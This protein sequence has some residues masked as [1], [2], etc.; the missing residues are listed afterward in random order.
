[1]WRAALADCLARQEAKK[2]EEKQ[3]FFFP[4]FFALHL[5][6][7]F[8]YSLVNADC[9]HAHTDTLHTLIFFLCPSKLTY[10]SFSLSNNYMWIRGKPQRFTCNISR[11]IR[12]LL[13][14]FSLPQKQVKYVPNAHKK[15]QQHLYSVITIFTIYLAHSFPQLLFFLSWIMD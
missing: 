4:S 13:H 6:L 1:M 7:V 2:A 5:L 15:K 8:H 3:H 12:V 11:S 9:T 14:V 10:L